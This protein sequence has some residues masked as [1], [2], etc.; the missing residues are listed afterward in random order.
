MAFFGSIACGM[1][2][3]SG[4]VGGRIG[5]VSAQVGAPGNAL[6]GGPTVAFAPRHAAE[7]CG[8]RRSRTSRLPHGR[9]RT[10]PPVISLRFAH[11]PIAGNRAASEIATSRSS[12]RRAAAS[13]APK[14]DAPLRFA[15]PRGEQRQPEHDEDDT[16]RHPHQEAGELLIGEAV[17]LPDR[18]LTAIFRIPEQTGDTVSNAPSALL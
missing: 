1:L 6:Q 16:G 17:Q 12:R 13:V 15:K 10:F 5:Q 3:P 18:R 9:V 7:W 8:R 14:P 4:H 11:R 2:Y